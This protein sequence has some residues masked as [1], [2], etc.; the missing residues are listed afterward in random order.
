MNVR[1]PGCSSE[2]E[3]G[4][5]HVQKVS[6][7]GVQCRTVEEMLRNVRRFPDM[8]AFFFVTG[9]CVLVAKF[10]GLP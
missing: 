7:L 9:S 1:V 10:A 5:R 3:F 2:S 8:N 4:A 6:H